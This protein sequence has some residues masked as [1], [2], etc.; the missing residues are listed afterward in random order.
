MRMRHT[1]TLS[2]FIRDSITTH[3]KHR[4]H[5][6]ARVCESHAQKGDRR[7]DDDDVIKC[8][9]SPLMCVR[10]HA[11]LKYVF[12]IYPVNYGATARVD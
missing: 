9:L 10:A 5:H 1:H 7:D 6:I 2:P 12:I 4:D 8:G 11:E 3:K